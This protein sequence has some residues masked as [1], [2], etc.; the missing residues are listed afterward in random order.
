MFTKKRNKS[1]SK[2]GGNQFAIV[3]N[4]QEGNMEIFY[5]IMVAVALSCII[6]FFQ[7]KINEMPGLESLKN[8]NKRSRL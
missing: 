8:C 1:G 7:K 2:T 4:D 3:F 6:M 5:G